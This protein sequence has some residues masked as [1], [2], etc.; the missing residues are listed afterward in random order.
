MKH[1]NVFIL[2]WLLSGTDDMNTPYI[3]LGAFQIIAG[4]L[5]AA[6]CLVKRFLSELQVTSVKEHSDSSDSDS[7]TVRKRTPPVLLRRSLQEEE[8][9]SRTGSNVSQLKEFY[10]L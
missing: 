8:W 4:G 1:W 6:I 7:V 5:I 9:R 10:P 2:E 3:V